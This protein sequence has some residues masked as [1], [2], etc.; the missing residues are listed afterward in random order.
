[1]KNYAWFQQ[2]VSLQI[3]A[4]NIKGYVMLICHFSMK[5]IKNNMH[6]FIILKS[7]D[8]TTWLGSNSSH[9]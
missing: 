4:H 7:F 1:M 8:I 3:A 2:S 5:R 6:D 9:R